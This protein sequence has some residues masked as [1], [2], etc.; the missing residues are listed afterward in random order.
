[1]MA[2]M[3][4]AALAGCSNSWEA[5]G[6]FVIAAT[7]TGIALAQRVTRK[8]FPDT[9]GIKPIIAVLIVFSMALV[10]L[11]VSS[12]HG[13]ITV[14]EAEDAHDPVQLEEIADHGHSHDGDGGTEQSKGHMHSHDPADHTHHLANLCSNAVHWTVRCTQHWPS[15]I[16]DLADPGTAY[17]IDRPPKP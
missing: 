7:R 4:N 17:G 1:M 9:A 16:S 12:V 3:A 10:L 5:V 8:L 13:S 15:H 6:C 2:G 14:I 11:P